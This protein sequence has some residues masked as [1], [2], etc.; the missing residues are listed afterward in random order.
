[1]F[2]Q[3]YETLKENAKI[4]T[5]KK[6]EEEAAERQ[7]REAEKHK[8]DVFLQALASNDGDVGA[9]CSASGISKT[10]LAEWRDI[11]PDFDQ[12]VQ[13]TI[14]DITRKKDIEKQEVLRQAQ[15][16]REISAKKEQF[17]KLYE[18]NN[19][20]ALKT[21]AELDL[22]SGTVQ[23]WRREDSTFDEAL[24]YIEKLHADKVHEEE[25]YKRRK[26]FKKILPWLLI[27]ILSFVC[28][29]GIINIRHKKDLIKAEQSRIE[30]QQQ[31]VAK[32]ESR[33][34]DFKQALE[35]ANNSNVDALGVASEIFV[36]IR[37]MEN[38][39][40]LFGRNESTKLRIDFNAK[41]DAIMRDLQIF[42]AESERISSSDTEGAR[43]L[44]EE[45]DNFRKVKEYKNIVAK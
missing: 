25:L 19:C 14:D 13:D 4:N 36:E 15:I 45:E 3:S 30:L 27:V 37:T 42:I 12:S 40:A 18:T 34:I 38:T 24:K 41:A 35:T 2:K 1:M 9:A 20:D 21:C 32:Y 7:K 6:L 29:L 23:Q 31:A 43:L 5:A 8:R 22:D 28:I 10:L 16:A 17:K 11:I 39:E 33:I 26:L 44:A